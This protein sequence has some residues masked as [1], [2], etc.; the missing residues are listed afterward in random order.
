MRIVQWCNMFFY[1]WI[2]V[3]LMYLRLAAVCQKRVIL[4]MEMKRWVWMTSWKLSVSAGSNP[5]VEPWQTVL[6][7]LVTS[8][9][10]F[11]VVFQMWW[12]AVVFIILSMSELCYPLSVSLVIKTK[13]LKTKILTF[14]LEIKTRTLTWGVKTRLKPHRSRSKVYIQHL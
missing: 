10:A 8:L 11:T 13:R 5:S 4:V 6:L 2:S 3:H 14:V 1:F 9:T 12:V 7:N